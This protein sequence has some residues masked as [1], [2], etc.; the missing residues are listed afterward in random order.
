MR[1]QYCLF[2][3]NF[4]LFQIRL[5]ASEK[6]FYVMAWVSTKITKTFL[7]Q[8]KKKPIFLPFKLKK[9]S[10]SS[11]TFFSTLRV[12]FPTKLKIQ[13]KSFSKNTQL[14]FQC[15]SVAFCVFLQNFYSTQQSIRKTSSKRHRPAQIQKNHP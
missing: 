11:V 3:L 2:F 8:L 1:K 5:Y 12:L 13:L 10:L 6:L 15:L 14:F 7:V 4:E 9:K